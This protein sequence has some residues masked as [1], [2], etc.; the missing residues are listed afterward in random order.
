MVLLFA[1]IFAALAMIKRKITLDNIFAYLFLAFS[2]LYGLSIYFVHKLK[3]YNRYSE[4]LKMLLSDEKVVHI[5]I[6]IIA[7]SI[8]TFSICIFAFKPKQE[9]RIHIVNH[10]SIYKCLF[11]VTY[12]VV[13]YFNSL[14]NWTYSVQGKA[15]NSLA[16]Y[17][18][19]FSTIFLIVIF[20]HP[21]KKKNCDFMYLI[22]YMLITL[23]ST[24]RTNML[25]VLIAFIYSRRNRMIYIIGG[26]LGILML[27]SARNGVSVLNLMYPILG[28][29]IFGS[30]GVLQAIKAIQL[31]GY[32][33]D[34]IFK[35]FNAPINWVLKYVAP[36]IQISELSDVV[37]RNEM[38]YYPLGGFYFISDAY[39]MNPMIG[40]VIYTV[41]LY[42]VY[43]ILQN[44]YNKAHSTTALLAISMLF[45]AIKGSLRTF[46]AM[47]A[48]HILVYWV[49]E[50]LINVFSY[51]R[52]I[53]VDVH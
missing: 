36:S 47:L 9:T 22:L 43:Y 5:A 11:W 7:I 48:F 41:L 38:K 53:V 32:S 25:I 28:E 4:E 52:K 31:E 49:I 33:Y 21:P 46:V 2:D 6:Q 18:R 1:N 10:I 34:S 16:A 44:E 26:I 20:N 42:V 15:V 24:Q 3:L 12:P 29:G 30:W 13:F 50:N 27:G 39:L 23:E 14:S 37:V 19:N 51:N 45:I 35:L 8:V 40:P 17:F